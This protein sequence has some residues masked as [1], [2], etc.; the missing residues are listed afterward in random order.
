M[1]YSPSNV[2]KSIALVKELGCDKHKHAK[3]LEN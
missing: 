2:F 1:N 3:I